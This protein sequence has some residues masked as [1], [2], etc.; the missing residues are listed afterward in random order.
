MKNRG[1]VFLVIV[2]NKEEGEVVA[3]IIL[4]SLYLGE[5]NYVS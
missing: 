4:T 2:H 3:V 5:Q 1:L